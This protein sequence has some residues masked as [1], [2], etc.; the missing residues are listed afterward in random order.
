[1]RLKPLPLALIVLSLLSAT[2]A[3]AQRRRPPRDGGGGQTPSTVQESI[4]SAEEKETTPAKMWTKYQELTT[5][6]VPLAQ[7][8]TLPCEYFFD[9]DHLNRKGKE[10]FLKTSNP[11]YIK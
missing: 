4:R 7:D 2:T 8:L 9:R 11:K 6:T 10:L 3:D 5:V 1:M